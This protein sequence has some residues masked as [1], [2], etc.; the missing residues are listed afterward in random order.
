LAQAV[1]AAFRSESIT[2]DPVANALM[3]NLPVTMT[4][5]VQIGRDSQT[6]LQFE[7]NRLISTAI[8]EDYTQ[9][10]QT[11]NVAPRGFFLFNDDGVCIWEG[12]AHD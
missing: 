10:I 1:T 7:N 5:Q 12:D 2:N 6:Q 8:S 4:H 11:I 9:K 3:T